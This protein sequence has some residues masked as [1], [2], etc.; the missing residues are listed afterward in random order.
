MFE[1]E[2]KSGLV[3]PDPGP[4]FRLKYGRAFRGFYVGART[5]THQTNN[6]GY[7]ERLRGVSSESNTVKSNVIGVGEK[8]FLSW[9]VQRVDEIFPNHW[10]GRDSEQSPAPLPW[11]AI[12]SELTTPDNE[13]WGIM[14]EVVR[15]RRYVNDEQLRNA[16]PAAF[17]NITPNSPLQMNNRTWKRIRLCCE[18]GGNHTD[19]LDSYGRLY[20]FILLFLTSQDVNLGVVTSIPDN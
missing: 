18:L 3:N 5:S 17:Q 4:T 20:R 16:V 6:G 2:A 12:G 13:L 1:L 9:E 11:P 19:V 15:K 7:P 8:Y 14:K 10:I